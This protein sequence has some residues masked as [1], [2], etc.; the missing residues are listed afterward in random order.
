[1][2]TLV[3]LS[4]GIYPPL[5]EAEG[6]AA[7]LR[8]VVG[9]GRVEVVSRG[10]RRY[11]IDVEAAAYFCCLEAIQNAAKHAGTAA[12]RVEVD[13]GPEALVLTVSDEG[14]GFDP[15]LVEVGTGLA[16]IR[17]RVDSAGGVVELSSS[18]GHGTRLR[19]VLPTPARLGSRAGG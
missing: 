16:N 7:A 12:A 8:A 9:D 6:V 10:D 14:P 13:A 15:A 5:L 17:D 19:V 11:P 2:A 4:Q 3:Q 1:M 18:P